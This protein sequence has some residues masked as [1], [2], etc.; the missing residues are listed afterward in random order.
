[1][2]ASSSLNYGSTSGSLHSET[3]S[4]ASSASFD[5]REFPLLKQQ[6]EIGQIEASTSSRSD[7][8]VSTLNETGLF[9]LAFATAIE[10][11]SDES[12]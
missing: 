9:Q 10:G 2:N 3:P 7:S 11:K 12:N 1:M 6:N 4:P 5:Q 8:S